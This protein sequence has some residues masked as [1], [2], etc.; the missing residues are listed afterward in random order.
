MK[1]LLAYLRLFRIEHAVLLAAAVLLS[2]LLSSNAA[3]SAMP[4][5][6]VLLV[7]MAVP[8][9]IEMGSFALNDYMDE[10]ADLENRRRDRPIAAGE[11]DPLEALVASAACYILGVLIAVDLPLSAFAI[12]AVFALLSVAY[13][14]K[15]KDLPLLGNIYIACTMAIPFLF[16]NIITT[17]SLLL[18][19]LLISLVAFVAGLGRELV[20]T[21]EDMEGDVKHR[22]SR[23]L[24]ALVGKRNSC[25]LAALLYLLLVPISF[26]PFAYGLRANLPSLGL[27][28]VTALAFAW[29]A[30]S[31][32]GNQEKANLEAAR[33]ASLF[34]L[35]VGLLG[36]A[37]S[38]L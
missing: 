37:A 1:K 16:G 22:K 15:L 14:W 24:P 38:L 30:W 4:A 20:K 21:A 9:L 7:S 33:K 19:V 25:L 36:Y 2:E 32:A 17:G 6:P 18:P 35:G 8:F 28:A 23:S 5:I 3:Q 34:A 29:M 12:A 27:V 13:N 10:K 26:L 31:V 11:I